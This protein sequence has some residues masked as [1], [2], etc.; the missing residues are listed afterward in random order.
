MLTRAAPLV[1]RGPRATGWHR[2]EEKD[3]IP[4]STRKGKGGQK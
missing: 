1:A 3:F 2:L 4:G